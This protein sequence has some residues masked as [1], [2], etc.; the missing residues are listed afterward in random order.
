MGDK[1]AANDKSVGI[2]WLT[3]GRDPAK[4]GTIIRIN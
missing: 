3:T 4:W 2:L 1:V